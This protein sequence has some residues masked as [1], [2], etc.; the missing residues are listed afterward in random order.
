MCQNII[1]RVPSKNMHDPEKH[2]WLNQIFLIFSS[3]LQGIQHITAGDF[4]QNVQKLKIDP[5]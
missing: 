2:D 1:E 4:V 3:L 5:P